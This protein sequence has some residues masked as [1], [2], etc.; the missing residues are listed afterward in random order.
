MLVNKGALV[1]TFLFI[2]CKMHGANNIKTTTL[3]Q[4]NER[5]GFKYKQIFA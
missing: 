4:D 2:Y 5:I 3:F 1:G